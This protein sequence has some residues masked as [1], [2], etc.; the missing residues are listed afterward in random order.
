MDIKKLVC[1]LVTVCFAVSMAGCVKSPQEDLPQSE[2]VQTQQPEPEPTPTPYSYPTVIYD[3]PIQWRDEN[4]KHLI[5]DAM[6]W[7]YSKEVCPADFASVRELFILSDQ[8]IL[9][10]QTPRW[11]LEPEE[12]G[13]DYVWRGKTYTE[14]VS[15]NLD[16]L[17][18]FLDLD[19][20]KVCLV[21]L[22]NTEFVAHIP[23]IKYLWLAG[24]GIEDVT[25]I[26]KCS[27][28]KELR[29]PGNN[30]S[31]IS[32]LA[33]MNL[34]DLFLPHNNSTD[35]SPLADMFRLPEELVLSFNNISDITALTPYNRSEALAYLNLRN[36]NISD[37]SPL[38]YYD[39]IG[40]LSLSYNNITD[41]SP[42]NHLPY[43]NTIYRI[44]NPE[45]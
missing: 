9:I 32:P 26:A 41:F 12:N 5:Y 24:C 29:L 18:N 21:Q 1:L 8:R 17:V 15:M 3:L 45:G 4:L 40:I 20:L 30:I 14:S 13:T 22:E 7:D 27:T 36:N 19:T 28:V 11:D 39:S 33:D 10:N 23:N 43:T 42:I 35:I 16:D 6:G 2:P 31:D 44:G 37:I 38:A 34:W 25:N